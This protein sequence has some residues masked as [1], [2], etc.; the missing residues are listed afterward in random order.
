MYNFYMDCVGG[1]PADLVKCSENVMWKAGADVKA[2]EECVKE[3]FVTYD[4]DGYESDNK[5]LEEDAEK[6]RF[7]GFTRHP[8]VTINKALY[9]GDLDGIDIFSAI[10]SSFSK[11]NRPKYCNRDFDIQVRMGKIDD[12]NVPIQRNI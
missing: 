8:A 6:A 3:S 4:R 9:R 12:L 5:Y 1:A 10:C 11:K 7:A 2:V